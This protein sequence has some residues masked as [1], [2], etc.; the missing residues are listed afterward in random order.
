[1]PQGKVSFHFVGKLCYG[2]LWS[3][4]SVSMLI[5]ES[6]GGDC[7]HNY[8]Y[9][10]A[11]SHS[12][13]IVFSTKTVCWLK[14]I[15]IIFNS[16]LISKLDCGDNWHE[17]SILC[18][19]VSLQFY[20]I[21]HKN[22]VGQN[23][24]KQNFHLSVHQGITQW[25]LEAWISILWCHITC[26]F[27]FIFC[28]SYASVEILWRG[29]FI[30]ML[31]KEW[32]G[33]VCRY[34]YPYNTVTSNTNFNCTFHEDQAWMGAWKHE[35]Q[36]NNY[37]LNLIMYNCTPEAN[38]VFRDV[39]SEWLWAMLLMFWRHTLPPPSHLDLCTLTI[40]M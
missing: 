2:Q 4:I 15:K 9:C 13:L 37:H 23:L 19:H 26:N 3:G 40:Q 18:Y 35:Y 38:S 39:N 32:Y 1:M 6:S 5:N 27:D 16:M 14:F 36:F 8:P 21:F 20:S 28:E 24:I 11:T 33:W 25:S 34:I 31:F 30:S 29:I 17:Y 10:V 7:R 22:D 12:T